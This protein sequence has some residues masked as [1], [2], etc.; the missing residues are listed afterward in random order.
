M[1]ASLDVLKVLFR[2]GKSEENKCPTMVRTVRIQFSYSWLEMA[3]RG[4]ESAT[5]T[6]FVS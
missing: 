4:L 1:T 2:C 6:C 3:S 5:A